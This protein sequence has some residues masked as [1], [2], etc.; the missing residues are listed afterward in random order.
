MRALLL[1]CALLCISGLAHA[2][3]VILN[4]NV[5][6]FSRDLVDP[7]AGSPTAE[8]NAL[9][10]DIKSGYVFDF[11]L[12]AGLQGSYN[13]GE[14]AGTDLNSYQLGPSVGYYDVKHTGLFITAT[15]HL[16]GMYEQ[17]TGA[18]K[19]EF[20][21]I[22]GLQ[23]DLAYPMELTDSIKLGPQLSY[24]RLKHEDSDTRVDRSTKELTPYFGLWFFF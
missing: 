6:Y 21:K 7:N 1:F 19:T 17:E 11:G 10:L 16:L 20:D 23:I 24:K 12:F 18:T 8:L 14:N 4:P 9:I 15:Y 5:T 13:I 2:Q 22:T 3:G